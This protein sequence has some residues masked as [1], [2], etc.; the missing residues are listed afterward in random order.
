[1]TRWIDPRRAIS[2][3]RTSAAIASIAIVQG[4]TPVAA[5]DFFAGKQITLIVGAGVGGGYD[6]QAR[7]TA[8]HLGKHIPGKPGIIVQNMP[9][10]IAAANHIYSTAPADGT[11]I[12]L[13]QRGMLLAKL[14]YP[15]GTRLRC[16]NLLELHHARRTELTDH[17]SFQRNL[18]RLSRR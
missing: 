14:I 13:I 1:M 16:R 18:R 12:A 8:R 15:T 17:D 6:L 7:L 3:L 4:A 2:V 5:E 10:R 9:A 11:T